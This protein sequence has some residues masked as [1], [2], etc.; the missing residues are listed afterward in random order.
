MNINYSDLNISDRKNT[1]SPTEFKK[2]NDKVILDHN[3]DNLQISSEIL[4]IF[5][6]NQTNNIV[7]DF[8]A[9]SEKDLQ[10][11]ALLM[12]YLPEFEELTFKKLNEVI[13]NANKIELK[14]QSINISPDIFQ[15]DFQPED[16]SYNHEGNNIIIR[17]SVNDYQQETADFTIKIS[18]SSEKQIADNFNENLLK[19]LIPEEEIS[20]PLIIKIDDK[21]VK[22]LD[23]ERKNDLIINGEQAI[24]E[25]EIHNL[26]RTLREENEQNFRLLNTAVNNFL[27][28]TIEMDTEQIEEYI[29]KGSFTKQLE[30]ISEQSDQNQK[31]Y[32]LINDAWLGPILINKMKTDSFTEKNS[33]KESTFINNLSFL[34]ENKFVYLGLFLIFIYCLFLLLRLFF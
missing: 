5:R 3:Q 8:P 28:E 9:V 34:F 10:L 18:L 27:E 16:V 14:Y 1:I 2:I 6:E 32:D 17:G 7:L 4:H 21:V 30:I 29:R 19:Q 23:L 12:K 25:T 24:G 11:W 22:T 20:R 31:K 15:A 13:I 26:N 33:W